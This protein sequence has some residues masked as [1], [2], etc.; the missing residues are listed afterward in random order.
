MD[1]SNEEKYDECIINC[2]KEI[3]I[4]V[5]LDCDKQEECVLD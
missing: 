1:Y 3:K 5:R 2:Q 4:K